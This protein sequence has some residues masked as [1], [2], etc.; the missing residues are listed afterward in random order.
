VEHLAGGRT[1]TTRYRGTVERL[2]DPVPP[3]AAPP[4]SGRATE[5]SVD[6]ATADAL[7]EIADRP[8]D[9]DGAGQ[10]DG[11]HL[12]AGAGADDDDDVRGDGGEEVADDAVP[13]E[14]DP[15]RFSRWM[16]SSASGG[17]MT[18]IALGLQHALEERRELPAFVMEA[19]GEPDDPDAPIS[20][21]FDPDDPTKTV[22][23]IRT[24][25]PRAPDEDGGPTPR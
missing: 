19:P 12:D 8:A 6:G 20:L 5:A 25:Q 4:G 14:H 18:G 10:A 13:S 16:R 17:I 23:V 3:D 1:D 2:P 11:T 15:L 22:A 21:H 9:P 7:D 24:P